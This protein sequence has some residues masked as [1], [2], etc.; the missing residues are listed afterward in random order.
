M[1]KEAKT[2]LFL[3][4]ICG[5][6][7]VGGVIG[8]AFLSRTDCGILVTSLHIITQNVKSV[9]HLIVCMLT[10]ID[11]LFVII[12]CKEAPKVHTYRFFVLLFT[13]VFLYQ[14]ACIAFPHNVEAIGAW[15]LIIIASLCYICILISKRRRTFCKENIRCSKETDMRSLLN[16]A[17]RKIR[18]GH[19]PITSIQFYRVKKATLEG[20][21]VYNVEYSD[22]VREN[23][24]NLNASLNT[25]LTISLKDLENFM[26]FQEF[27]RGYS[28]ACNPEIKEKLLKALYETANNNIKE[29]KSGLDSH[30]SSVTDINCKDA[31][32]SRLI[33]IYFSCLAKAESELTDCITGIRCKSLNIA[34]LNANSTEIN[35]QLFTK[36]HTGF[37][38]ALLLKE[39]YVFYYEGSQNSAKANRRYVS[40][41][42]G[43]DDTEKAIL[44][45]ITLKGA[46]NSEEVQP[47]LLKKLKSIK[48]ELERCYAKYEVTEDE[49]EQE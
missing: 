33:L 7:N 45:L 28:A 42:L 27:Y 18:S 17:K 39:P 32:I 41:T 21:A 36:Y 1:K 40:F 11:Y 14:C 31:C 23:A 29:L 13:L 20:N 30:I 24:E 25:Q 34:A 16:A 35:Q 44:V 47:H 43:N 8:A 12:T 19:S 9:Y 49:K 48:D 6:V 46:N 3:L 10:A 2:S 5:L 37:L 22:S 38:G 26:A 4:A 15:S